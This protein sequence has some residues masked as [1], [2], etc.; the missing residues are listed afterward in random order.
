MATGRMLNKS[1]S[2]DPELN[3]MSSQAQLLYLKTIPHLDRDG[4]ITGH[5]SKLWATIDPF[6]ADLLARMGEYIQEWIHA[7]L[8]QRYDTGREAI[9]FL[10]GFRKNNANIKYEQEAPSK[11][12]PPPGWMRTR[13]GLAP[14]SADERYLL[15]QAFDPRSKYSQNLLAADET[16]EVGSLSVVGR[17]QLPYQ[18]QDQDQVVVVDQDQ[19]ISFCENGRDCQGKPNHLLQFDDAT[20]K[21]A[22][23]QLGSV[24]WGNDWLNYQDYL[25]TNAAENLIVLLEWIW[26]FT[27][28]EPDSYKAITNLPGYV[29]KCVKTGKRPPLLEQQRQALI[30][31]VY[32]LYIQ[33]A[34]P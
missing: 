19:C 8:V 2:I 32:D 5:P 20:L 30:D 4:L 7:N 34:M 15:S 1:I 28:A 9:L 10:T 6:H 11:F 18:D 27:K 23:F 25:A 12:P 26:H 14:A 24:L 21:D 31:Q 33:G 3:G 13:Y 16:D 22:A 29:H 17:H